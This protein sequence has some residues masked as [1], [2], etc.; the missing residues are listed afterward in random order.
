MAM[1]FKFLFRKDR[2][3]LSIGY[4]VESNEVDEACYDLL[5]SEARLTSLFAIAKGDLPT[6]HWYK[7]GRPIVPIGARGALVSWS[8]S[9]FEYLMPPLVMQEPQGGI[10]NQTNNLIVR[11]QMNHGRRLGTPWG[12]SEAAFNARRG[13]FRKRHSMPATTN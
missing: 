8:G 6:E 7:L 1:D 11:E 3:L 13:A 12:I 9:M 2:R 10:L 5:A 4:R